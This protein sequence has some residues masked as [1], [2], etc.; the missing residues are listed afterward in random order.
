MKF[1]F[2]LDSGIVVGSLTCTALDATAFLSSTPTCTSG[3]DSSGNPYIIVDNVRPSQFTYQLTIAGVTNANA[4]K[5]VTPI[6][7]NACSSAANCANDV[8]LFTN[9]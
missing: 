6:H 5:Q 7:C 2:P 1:T 8:L 9:D 4:A 3:F